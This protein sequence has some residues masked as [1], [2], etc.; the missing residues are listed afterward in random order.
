MIAIIGSGS[1]RRG[2][3]YIDTA[4]GQRRIEPTRIYSIDDARTFLAGQGFD[5]DALAKKVEGTF[6]SGF[7]RASKPPSAACCGPSCCD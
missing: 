5:V 1:A 7:I 6:M 3:L 4:W 2:P